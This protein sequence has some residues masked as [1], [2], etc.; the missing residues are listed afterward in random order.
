M[1]ILELRRRIGGRFVLSKGR[2]RT[3]T[4]SLAAAESAFEA[5]GHSLKEL[6]WFCM[7][8]FCMCPFDSGQIQFFDVA[9]MQRFTKAAR[10]LNH[11]RKG[12][13]TEVKAGEKP[14][15]SASIATQSA[16]EHGFFLELLRDSISIAL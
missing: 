6:E 10:L 14:I 4:L 12:N 9:F 5:S 13:K 1:A 11:Q 16:T 3:C 15:Q 7:G 2:V 8:L